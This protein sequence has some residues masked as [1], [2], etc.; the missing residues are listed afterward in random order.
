MSKLK[1]VCVVL[2]T[3]N[4][5]ELLTRC[6]QNLLQQ[7]YAVAKIKIIDNNST[8][9]T[10]AFLIEN[11]LLNDSATVANRTLNTPD[12]HAATG[13]EVEHIYLETNTGGAGGFNF[14]I[15]EAFNEGFDLIWTMD[16]DGYPDV[17]CLAGLVA[18]SEE[19]DFISPLVIDEQNHD[20][21]SF[22]I[23]KYFTVAQL[24][25][26]YQQDDVVENVANPFNGVLFTHS[27]IAQIGK[28]KKDMFI[29]GDE[30]EFQSRARLHKARICTVICARHYH[31]K[32][33][34]PFVLVLG[35]F[36]VNLPDGKLRRYCYFR[37][38]TY[39]LKKYYSRNALLKWYVKYYFLFLTKFDFAGLKLFHI[40]S[41]HGY[42][43][44]FSHHEEY[45]S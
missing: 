7:S 30:N 40:A 32:N 19:Y 11:G 8:D 10:K 15:N 23:G 22:G 43:E 26:S 4:R 17:E 28:P 12:N 16:D 39:I 18:R 31:P 6:L 2:V 29:W 3:F 13:I 9:G 24:L 37:N 25:Q 41:R 14:G 42:K 34:V 38:Y 33:R 1:S 27:L 36:K 35:R 44:D 5:K 21:L 20:Q 45:K